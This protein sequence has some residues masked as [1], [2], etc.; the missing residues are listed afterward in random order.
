MHNFQPPAN[1]VRHHTRTRSKS[2]LGPNHNVTKMAATIGAIKYAKSDL[3][4]LCASP[5]VGWS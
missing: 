3:I 5:K 4:F 1:Q 2:Q